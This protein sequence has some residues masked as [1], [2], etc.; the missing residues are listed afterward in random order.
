[1]PKIQEN[2]TSL[3]LLAPPFKNRICVLK[4]DMMAPLS[5]ASSIQVFD[6]FMIA[7]SSLTPVLVKQSQ[8][9]E[10]SKPIFLLL[11]ART[12]VFI[13]SYPIWR[14]QDPVDQLYFLTCDRNV[15]TTTEKTVLC[16]KEPVMVKAQRQINTGCP[17]K[18]LRFAMVYFVYN[19]VWIIR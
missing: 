18:L 4:L 8:Q 1:M 17:W 10:Q 19:A 16:Q 5:L 9:D 14:C 6:T 7:I 15:S 3:F 12:K 2:T 11:A 13:Y